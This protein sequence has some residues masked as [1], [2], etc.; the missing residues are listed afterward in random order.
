MNKM[1]VESS[2]PGKHFGESN[3]RAVIQ[4]LV[5]FTGEKFGNMYRNDNSDHQ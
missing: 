5:S 4:A 1:S 2:F 3:R